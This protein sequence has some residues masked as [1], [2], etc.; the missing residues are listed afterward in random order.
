MNLISSWTYVLSYSS[1]NFIPAAYRRILNHILFL[2]ILRWSLLLL[3]SWIWLWRLWIDCS[4]CWQL[5][6]R[7]WLLISLILL[8]CLYSIIGLEIRLAALL[9]LLYLWLVLFSLIF[10]CL[11]I[12]IWQ[13]LLILL[14]ILLLHKLNSIKFFF[15]VLLLIFKFKL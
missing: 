5:D 6:N 9:L 8:W 15:D 13:R 4:S 1:C 12:D 14:R 10:R 7:S 2:I 11:V 3:S